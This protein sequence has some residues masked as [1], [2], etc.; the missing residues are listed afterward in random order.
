MMKR[1]EESVLICKRFVY[2]KFKSNDITAYCKKEYF[3][4]LEI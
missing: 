4:G 2:P 3:A 1:K